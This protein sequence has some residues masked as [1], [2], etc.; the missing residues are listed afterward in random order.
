MQ[1]SAR[2]VKDL[3]FLFPPSPTVILEE[4]FNQFPRLSFFFSLHGSASECMVPVG[5]H[6]DTPFPRRPPKG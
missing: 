5:Y 6:P 4:S 3:L 2:S 1:F